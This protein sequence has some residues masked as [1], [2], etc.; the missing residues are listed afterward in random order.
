MCD[1]CLFPTMPPYKALQ[2]D[3]YASRLV[4][5]IQCTSYLFLDGK[6]IDGG[7]SKTAQHGIW[8]H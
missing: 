2:M 8:H 4:T 1:P 3:P 7:F 6:G 5:F